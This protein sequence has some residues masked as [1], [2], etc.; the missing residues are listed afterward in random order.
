MRRKI[1]RRDQGG[2]VGEERVIAVGEHLGQ[3]AE[4]R[5]TVPARAAR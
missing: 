2:D 1:P 3:A 5:E 4:R